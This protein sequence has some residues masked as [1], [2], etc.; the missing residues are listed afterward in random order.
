MR[1]KVPSV[2]GGTSWLRR[3]FPHGRCGRRKCG[4]PRNCPAERKWRKRTANRGPSARDW[5]ARFSLDS[6]ASVRRQRPERSRG[7]VHHHGADWM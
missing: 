4:Y 2:A 6:S 1:G 7:I 3:V 5:M